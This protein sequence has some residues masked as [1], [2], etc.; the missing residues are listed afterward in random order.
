M[1]FGYYDLAADEAEKVD[2]LRALRAQFGTEVSPYIEVAPEFHAPM[3]QR[4]AMRA[5]MAAVRK[6]RFQTVLLPSVAA[7]HMHSFR[8]CELLMGFY[9][10]GIQIALGK[11]DNV[12]SREQAEAA[13]WEAEW[14]Y[15]ATNL[16][17]PLITMETCHIRD[18]GGSAVIYL[19]KDYRRREGFMSIQMPLIEAVRTYCEQGFYL[20]RADVQALYYIS[21]PLAEEMIKICT[22]GNQTVLESIGISLPQ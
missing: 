8:A 16:S 13:V 22:V 11:P 19:E 1:K 3:H 2:K 14:E 18:T 10:K 15:V 7:L 21:K 5:L 12:L 4:K 17:V 9:D 20:Y 6:G